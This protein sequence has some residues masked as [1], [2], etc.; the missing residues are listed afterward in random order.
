MSNKMVTKNEP[1]SREAKLD[2]AIELL[3]YLVA[4]HLWKAG[5]TQESIGKHL[6]IAKATVGSM[7]KGVRRDD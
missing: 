3:Q 6:H 2:T 1:Q 4:I 7:L 5:V